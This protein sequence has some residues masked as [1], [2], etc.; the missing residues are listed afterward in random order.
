MEILKHENYTKLSVIINPYHAEYSFYVSHSSPIFI[1]LTCN[2]PDI[3]MDIQSGQQY[4]PDQM[5]CLDLQS[6]SLL[7]MLQSLVK[8]CRIWGVL[9]WKVKGIA[10]CLLLCLLDILSA[11]SVVRCLYTWQV[12]SLFKKIQR[13][14]YMSAHVLL[15]LLNELGKRDKMRACRAIYLY[16]ATSLINSIIQEHNVRFYLSYEIKIT[17]KS[18][19]WRENVIILSLCMQ[20]CYG[21]HNVSRKSVNH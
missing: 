12:I 16:Y 11:S 8:Y 5:T 18:H 15:N 10:F 19:F 17:L 21:R 6:N 9:T 13:G 7:T 20:R 14:S 4:D 2:N 3:T 1:L